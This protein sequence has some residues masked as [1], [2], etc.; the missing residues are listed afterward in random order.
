MLPSPRSFLAAAS[1]ALAIKQMIKSARGKFIAAFFM[2]WQGR[3]NF[4]FIKTRS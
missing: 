4:L 2:A 3:I 1:D